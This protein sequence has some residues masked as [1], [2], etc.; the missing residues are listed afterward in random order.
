M[1]PPLT[2][3]C[4]REERDG[5]AE[6]GGEADA[7]EGVGG[8]GGGVRV[9]GVNFCR[10]FLMSPGSCLRSITWWCVVRG[11]WG[12]EGEGGLACVPFCVTL[13]GGAE[14]CDVAEESGGVC[15]GEKEGAGEEVDIGGTSGGRDENCGENGVTGEVGSC[16]GMAGD[17]GTEDSSCAREGGT[18]TEV[19]KVT[20]VVFGGAK[21]KGVEFEEVVE[22]VGVG[23][24]EGG[25]GEGGGESKAMTMGGGG[26]GT[27]V[28]EEGRGVGVL[29]V[30]GGV[31]VVGVFNFCPEKNPD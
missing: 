2:G 30:L 7:G 26:G 24:E 21:T 20:V 18:G 14:F 27:E 17:E 10:I 16:G 29:A 3:A 31:G 28:E 19:G 9:A 13:G 11:G 12:M 4:A 6:E 23:F 1:F 22:V 15:A 25:G 8:R 5:E